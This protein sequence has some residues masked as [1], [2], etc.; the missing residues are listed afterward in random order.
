MIEGKIIPGCGDLRAAFA[1]RQSVFVEEQGFSPESEFDDT[2]GAALHV[3]VLEGGRPAATA[4]LY[5][6]DGLWHIGRVA[7]LKEF[8][9]MGI[10]QVAMRMLMRKAETLGAKEVYVG[11]QKQAEKFYGSL[12]FYPCGPGYEEEGVPHIPMKAPASAE[13]ACALCAH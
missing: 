10:G 3:L 8:R 11:A 12:G 2:D 13:C 6:Q 7:V 4:R 9:G 1:I 5:E